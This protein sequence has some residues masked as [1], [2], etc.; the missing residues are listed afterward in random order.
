MSEFEAQIRDTC[1][2]VTGATELSSAVIEEV[3]SRAEAITQTNIDSLKA[4]FGMLPTE[5]AKTMWAGLLGNPATKKV[6]MPWQN[7]SDFC[8]V[9]RGVYSSSTSAQT[10]AT[11]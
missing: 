11:V 1:S 7:D 9:L 5:A 4:F 3:T 10:S 8:T 2:D 6:V